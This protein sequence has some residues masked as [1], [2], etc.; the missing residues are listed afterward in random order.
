M[1]LLVGDGVKTRWPAASPQ[2]NAPPVTQPI[3]SKQENEHYD[4]E[5]LRGGDFQIPR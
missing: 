3:T 5:Q 1:P 2:F 4:Q